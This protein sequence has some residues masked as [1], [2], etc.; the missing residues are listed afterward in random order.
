MTIL[1]RRASLRIVNQSSVPTLLKRVQKGD[2]TLPPSL[3]HTAQTLLIYMSK[4]YPALYQLHV[5]ELAKALADEKNPKL[6]EVSL[7]ALA[8][9]AQ[10]D[11]KHV[12]HDKYVGIFSK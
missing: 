12:P 2:G 9:V 5:G 6:V 1:I 7:Q 8:A 11:E 10:L 3:S 4:N